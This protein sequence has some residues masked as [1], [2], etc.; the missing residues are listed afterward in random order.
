MKVNEYLKSFKFLK[1]VQ[2]SA[3]CGSFLLAGCLCLVFVTAFVSLF[4][5]LHLISWT[6]FYNSTFRTPIDGAPFQFIP[7]SLSKH[8][9]NCQRSHKIAG[10]GIN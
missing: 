3:F 1:I 5:Y 7:F 8:V 9:A 6:I 10:S 2:I 4:F